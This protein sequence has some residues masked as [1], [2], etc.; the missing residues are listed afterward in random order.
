MKR[1]TTEVAAEA[2]DSVRVT[3]LKPHTHAG[4]DRLVGEEIDITAAQRT[5]LQS[6][7]VVAG[8]AQEK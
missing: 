8:E 7:G 4:K 5:W 1:D 2:S 6:L 3:L